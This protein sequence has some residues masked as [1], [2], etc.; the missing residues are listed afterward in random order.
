MS[1]ISV[2]SPP[3]YLILAFLSL[4][5]VAAVAD[6]EIGLDNQPR[7]GKNGSIA[8]SYKTA[9][10]VSSQF[11]GWDKNSNNNWVWAGTRFLY[12]D[13][14]PEYTTFTGSV[15]NLG[16]EYTGELRSAIPSGQEWTFDWNRKENHA[17]AVGYGIE[18]KVD[19]FAPSLVG[20]APGIVLLP[21]NTGWQLETDGQ[22]RVK[23]VFD[24]PLQDIAESQG[25]IRALFF[26]SVSVGQSSTKMTISLPAGSTT[27]TQ[28]DQAWGGKPDSSWVPLALDQENSPV[29][30]SFLNDENKPIDRHGFLKRQGD[31]LVFEDGTEAR[32]W[33]T[34]LQA[35]ALFRTDDDNIPLQAK[36]IAKLG[37]NLVRIH[38]MDSI[39]VRPNIFGDRAD[40]TLHLLASSFDK[41]DRWIY[42]LEQNGIYVWLDLHVG[43]IL[44]DKD[45][46]SNF[47]EL[48]RRK[49]DLR[50]YNYF[51]ESI[52]AAMKQFNEDYLGHLNPYTGHAY[53]ND[54]GIVS[55]LITNEND[56]TRHFGNLMLPNK[57]APLHHEVFSEEATA[58]AEA[59]GFS[60]NRVT[61]TWLPGESKLFL[62]D[63]EHRF[64]QRMI[65]H[66]VNTVGFEGVLMTTS[67]WGNMSLNGIASLTDGDMIDVHQYLG[68]GFLWKDPRYAA[69]FVSLIAAAQVENMPLAISEW[70]MSRYPATDRF[71]AP[72]YMASIASLQG[73]DMPIL[74]GYSQASLNGWVKTDNW[75]S[76]MD[77]GL[78]GI[79]PAAALLYRRGDVSSAVSTYRVAPSEQELF[80]QDLS[81]KTSTAIRTLAEQS[82]LI[83]HPAEP[84]SLPWLHAENFSG[85]AQDILD[86]DQDYLGNVS[87]VTSDTGEITRNWRDKTFIVD[88]DRSK[89]AEGFIAGRYI[90]LNGVS[91][92]I[93]KPL[94]ALV[95]VQSLSNDAISQ[96]RSILVSVIARTVPV[97]GS[98]LGEFLSEEI[99]GDISIVAPAGLTVHAVLASG[100]RIPA[101]YHVSGDSYRIPLEANPGVRWFILDESGDAGNGGGGNPPPSTGSVDIVLQD[102]LNGYTGTEDAW[103]DVWLKTTNRGSD[104]KLMDKDGWFRTL[105]RFP[106]FQSEGG[107]VP[108]GAT[109]EKAELGLYKI[110]YYDHVF[111][112]CRVL[113]PWRESSVNWS[114]RQ[115]GVPW[116]EGGAAKSGVDIAADCEGSASVDFSPEQWLTLDVTNSVQAIA[117]G[118]AN[119]HGW[120]LRGLSGN[121]NAKRFNSSEATD[122]AFRPRLTVTYSSK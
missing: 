79:M 45:G 70:N 48:S 59:N 3:F 36:R 19:L 51:N 56:L 120:L 40:N 4:H 78:M 117:T 115:Q 57:G 118:A 110:S 119:N 20:H 39:W 122:S 114:Y 44:T 97:S 49:G 72:I 76:Y 61:R 85:V 104:S 116:A 1:I 103:L 100:E 91:L 27:Y 55:A 68:D 80:Y 102:G 101:T 41:L 17:N 84:A 64:N 43:R 2:L 88:S 42:H 32:F 13:E 24:P 93:R 23:V 31:R 87:S 26:R 46:I 92:D 82:A 37:F 98:H 65:D 8:I 30:L 74:Y 38:H 18:F 73:W 94:A 14:T 22:P 47:N 77:P 34:N 12:V 53:A 63:V 112:A 52:E 9:G 105:I 99:E 106:I 54:P 113:Q 6:W 90:D 50:G 66:L 16:I 107:P 5:P 121:N 96:A 35:A 71:L 60:P 29:D 25:R 69:N 21:N 75:S 95:A 108:D 109:I 89:V 62:G 67:L 15:S 7:P 28:V 111:A 33:G 11:I 58:F 86:L 10:V 81:A 83:L